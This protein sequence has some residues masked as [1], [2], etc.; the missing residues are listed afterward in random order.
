MFSLATPGG[1]GRCRGDRVCG[2]GRVG[3]WIAQDGRVREASQCCFEAQS[4]RRTRES[5]SHRGENPTDG[6]VHRVDFGVEEMAGSRV[7]ESCAGIERERCQS[8]ER[9][10]SLLWGVEGV[11]VLL[12]GIVSAAMCRWSQRNRQGLGRLG[13]TR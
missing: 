1:D 12:A 8:G 9:G 2:C 13:L 3:G 4:R 7:A 6:R 5:L 10:G 11:W